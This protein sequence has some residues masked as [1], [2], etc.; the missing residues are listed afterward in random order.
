MTEYIIGE[1]QSGKTTELIKKANMENLLILTGT[2]TMASGICAD[3]KKMGINIHAM[4]I[5]QFL[6]QPRQNN[7]NGILIDELSIFLAAL[8]RG[9]PVYGV[10]ITDYDNFFYL[11]DANN[12][13][14][15]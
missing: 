4:S 5:S 13:P 7:Y 6:N 9:I 1:R 8:C 2:A 14:K 3:A 10:T 11:S 15:R 12:K